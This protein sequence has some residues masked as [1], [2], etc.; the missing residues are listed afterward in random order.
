ME[1]EIKHA[2]K[3]F[4]DARSLIQSLTERLRTT[5]HQLA[6]ERTLVTYT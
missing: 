5:E 1:E 2:K 4:D 6:V 3:Q